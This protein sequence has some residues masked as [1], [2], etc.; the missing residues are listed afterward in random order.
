VTTVHPKE[1]RLYDRAYLAWLRTKPCCVCGATGTTEAAHIRLNF[2]AGAMKP[3]DRNAVPLCS[4]HHRESPYAEHALGAAEFW[5]RHGLDP[6]AIAAKLYA[7]FGGKGGKPRK[8]RTIIR[9]RLPKD[10]RTKIQT[11]KRP[12][13]KR[14]FGK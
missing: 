6:F 1:P 7:A 3:H 8:P 11:S 12:W 2:F 5:K 13:P 14:G 4:W 9:P 10:K